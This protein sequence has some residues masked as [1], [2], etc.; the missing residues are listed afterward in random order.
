MHNICTCTP[1]SIW[2]ILICLCKF[3]NLDQQVDLVGLWVLSSEN[4][5]S[6]CYNGGNAKLWFGGITK[7]LLIFIIER[8]Q[9]VTYLF[10]CSEQSVISCFL[11]GL[12]KHLETSGTPFSLQRVFHQ[13]VTLKKEKQWE[14]DLCFGISVSSSCG[15]LVVMENLSCLFR[16]GNCD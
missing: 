7:Q 6:A 13:P 3:Q 4:V 14:I 2:E 1:S 11:S 16:Y 9:E 8:R 12:K 15:S 5:D 10:S